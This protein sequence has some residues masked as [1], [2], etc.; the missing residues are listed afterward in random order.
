[1]MEL[2]SI[3]AL[4]NVGF[5]DKDTGSGDLKLEGFLVPGE[6]GPSCGQSAGV[7][8]A[9]GDNATAATLVGISRQSREGRQNGDEAASIQLTCMTRWAPLIPL[10]TMRSC[11]MA[12]SVF[13][14]KTDSTCTTIRGLRGQLVPGWSVCCTRSA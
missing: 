11:M 14:M 12:M 2:W 10:P 8:R 3:L 6:D 13:V 1:M 5:Y 7:A 9:C 4:S